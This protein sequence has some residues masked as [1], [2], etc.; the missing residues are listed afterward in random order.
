MKILGRG[1]VD[2]TTRTRNNMLHERVKILKL[3]TRV[4]LESLE[5]MRAKY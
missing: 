4:Y 5:R 3:E 2:G 1:E